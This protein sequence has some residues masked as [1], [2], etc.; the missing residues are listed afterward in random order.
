[1]I[2]LRI[3]RT[4]AC[5]ALLTL[6]LA[7]GSGLQSPPPLANAHTSSASLARAVLSALAARDQAALLSLAITEQEFREHVWPEL[8][9]S[10]P[11]RN[12]PHSFVWGDLKQKSDIALTR[13]LDEHGGRQYTLVRVDYAAETTRYETFSVHRETVL[14]V[15]DE[16]DAEQEIR[17]YGSTLEKAGSFKVFSYVVD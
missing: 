3:A 12:L 6:H 11:E 1:L 10:R 15:R 14:V 16:S 17:V 4:A 5:A 2:D 7:C 13:T 8:P 9:A